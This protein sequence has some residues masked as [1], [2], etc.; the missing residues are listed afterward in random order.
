MKWYVDFISNQQYVDYVFWM[1]S[2]IS[3]MLRYDNGVYVI[4]DMSI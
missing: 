1:I 2:I 3:S 4:S